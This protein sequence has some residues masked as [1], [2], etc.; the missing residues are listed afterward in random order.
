MDVDAVLFE[1]AERTVT[2]RNE[3][4]MTIVTALELM[5][6]G[7]ALPLEP[8]LMARVQKRI[9]RQLLGREEPTA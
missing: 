6:G 4:W 1:V 8:D 3:E 2:L 5:Q 9:F 7:Q